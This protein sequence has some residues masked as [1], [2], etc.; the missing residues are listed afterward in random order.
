[1][2]K[3]IF[4]SNQK[5]LR[6]G[7]WLV[8]LVLV[9][10]F[11]AGIGGQLFA[12]SFI[13]DY[14][15]AEERIAALN[16]TFYELL[17][18]Y[19]FLTQEEKEGPLEIVIRRSEVSAG[20]NIAKE[21]AGGDFLESL[22]Q[23]IV[24]FFPLQQKKSDDFLLG[25]YLRED[26]LGR[27]F[28]LTNDGWLVT[29]NQVITDPQDEYLAVRSK[30]EAYPVEEIISDPLTPVV[31]VK[32]AASNLPV[33]NFDKNSRVLTGQTFIAQDQEGGIKI[34]TIEDNF[35][36]FGQ[37]LTDFILSS[38]ELDN[39]YL[40]DEDLTNL[41]LA[42]PVVNHQNQVIGLVVVAGKEKLIL[43]LANF[44]MI[45]DDVL[46]EK[47]ISRVLLGVE[48]LNLDRL[49][50]DL[51]AHPQYRD[52]N[53]GALIYQN[54]QLGITGVAVDSPAAVAGLKNGQVILKVEGEAIDSQKSLS[55]L[56][57]SYNPEEEIELTVWQAGE[58][59]KV[60]VSLKE[61]E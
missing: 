58:E 25:A 14:F 47:K 31:F 3:K 30:G 36:R 49:I 51:E 17:A 33:L 18:K 38:E 2:L 9:A 20:L 16:N 60:R 24:D 6:L 57:Q 22:E 4:P 43:P 52:I 44:A 29:S 21:V 10:G 32:I 39:Y 34:G 41:A 11:L 19:N 12:Q 37:Q 15:I 45:I 28:I 46:K 55:Q 53:Q 26:S 7:I 40:T 1:M 42:E 23:G 13:F 5:K 8:V 61:L 56:I 35:Y 54:K 50:L 59:I 27:G 48:Y